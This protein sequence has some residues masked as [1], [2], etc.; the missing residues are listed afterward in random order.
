MLQR[1]SSIGCLVLVSCL[2][3][4][5]A[6]ASDGAVDSRR[7]PLWNVSGR[8]D[9]ANGAEYAVFRQR[10]RGVLDITI[11]HTCAPGHIERGSGRVSGDRVTGRVTPTSGPPPGCV[12]FATFDVRVDPDG[13]RMRV[14]TQPTSDPASS[15]IS[16][17]GAPARWC[18][19]GRASPAAAGTSSRCFPPSAD[20]CRR[21]DRTRPALWPRRLQ[22]ASRP[23]RTAFSSTAQ[24]LRHFQGACLLRR[25]QRH[26]PPPPLHV[27]TVT[28]R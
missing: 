24:S 9:G 20:F 2:L 23:P 17:A 19:S 8:W 15:S 7:T 25:F 4:G 1:L 27:G 13:R 22:G 26:H 12:Q 16:P 11:H 28:H 10:K 14:A 6:G 3:G 18:A 21:G 5:G